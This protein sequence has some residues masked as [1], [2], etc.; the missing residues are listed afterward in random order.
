VEYFAT[1][2]Q[3]N[4]QRLHS[5]QRRLKREIAHLHQLL[6]NAEMAIRNCAYESDL[7]ILK[8]ELTDAKF[9]LTEVTQELLNNG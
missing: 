8:D 4:S 3:M 2:K 9:D 1:V 5:K 6:G 7:P